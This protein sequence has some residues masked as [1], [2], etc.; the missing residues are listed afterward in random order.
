M[1]GSIAYTGSLTALV[2]AITLTATSVEAIAHALPTT[3]DIWGIKTLVGPS[4]ASSSRIMISATA[5][6]ITFTNSGEATVGLSAWFA[7][8]HSMIR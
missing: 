5:T 1:A 6:T 8:L 2:S 7:V 4:G 3:P